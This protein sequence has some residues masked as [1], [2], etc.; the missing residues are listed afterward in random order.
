M[1]VSKPT[2]NYCCSEFE[3]YTCGPIRKEKLGNKWC[4]YMH[5]SPASIWFIEEP[6]HFC[7]FCGEAK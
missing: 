3:K 4:L 7:P 2:I 1:E 5:Q 6:I